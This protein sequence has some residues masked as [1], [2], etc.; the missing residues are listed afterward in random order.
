MISRWRGVDTANSAILAPGLDCSVFIF[1]AGIWY[2]L[3][4]AMDG[5]VRVGRQRNKLLYKWDR[6]A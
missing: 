3:S 6:I 4:I 1:P 5:S 2:A